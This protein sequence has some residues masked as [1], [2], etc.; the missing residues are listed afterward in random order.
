MVDRK[1]E[2]PEGVPPLKQYY[3]YLTAGCNLACQHCWITPAYQ[4][5]GGT[6]GH[7]DFDLFKLAVEEGIPLGLSS[8]KLTGGE[9][10]LHPDFIRMVDLLLEKNL[11]LT[12]ET[13]GTLMTQEMAHYL[14][15]KSTLRFIS[16]SLD[17]AKPETHDRFRGVKGSH[18][19]ALKGLSALVEVGYHP[20]VI[21][22]LHV[23]NVDEIELLVRLAENIGAGSVKFNIVQPSGR[24]ET[25]LER[26]Q[27]LDIGRLLDIGHWVEYN[28]QKVTKIELYF[29]WPMAFHSL[30][31]LINHGDDN[32]GI[33][34]IL[35]ILANGQLAM[36]GMGKE[37]PELC[38][39]ILGKE[40]VAK[41]WRS[42]PT[43]IALRQNLSDQLEGIC[44]NC[45]FRQ[46]CLG[47]CVAENYYMTGRLTG[48]N[49]FCEQV[50]EHNRFPVNRKKS[51]LG[52]R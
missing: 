21:M 44:S 14:R 51:Y 38:Y 26:G 24:G 31:R 39:G 4:P 10:L 36:C 13:N 52:K 22:S 47:H 5:N 12:I 1:L 20:Q 35:G 7:L 40:Q 34:N 25:M 49:W 43:L 41:V 6:G 45:L 30:R 42:H 15:E 32:C 33:Y 2:L 50:E 17:G 3:V 19:R 8:V 29:S 27:I 18:E 28:L 37:V 46:N 16:V 9:P 48:A 11:G 23:G